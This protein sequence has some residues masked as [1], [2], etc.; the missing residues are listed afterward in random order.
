MSATIIA[1]I[2][3][4]TYTSKNGMFHTYRLSVHGGQHISAKYVGDN[5]PKVYDEPYVLEGH[6][7]TTE[8]YGRQFVI[9]NWSRKRE[10]TQKP[11]LVGDILSGA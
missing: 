5:A 1:T 3:K 11:K 9:K 7:E 10:T 2:N 4:K 8:K 6:Y